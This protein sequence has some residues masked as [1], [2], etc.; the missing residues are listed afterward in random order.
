MTKKSKLVLAMASMLGITAGAAAVS[1][2]AWFTTTKTAQVNVNNI[3]VYSTSS[4]LAVSWTAGQTPVGCQQGDP[5]L[6]GL[7]V[8]GSYSGTALMQEFTTTESTTTFTLDKHPHDIVSVDIN[9]GEST[10]TV[11]SFNET[12]NVVTL[13]TA[14]ATGK[15]VKITYH[16]YEALTDLSS[17]DGQHIYKPTWTANGEGQYCTDFTA[18]SEGYVQFSMTL[19]ATGGSPLRVFLNSGASVAPVNTLNND[20]V[21][22]SHIARVAIIDNTTTRFVFQENTSY[23]SKGVSEAYTSS[24]KN[25]RL[26]AGE[27]DNDCWDLLETVTN[28]LP[29]V[30]GLLTQTAITNKAS[31]DGEWAADTD[32]QVAAESYITTVNAG[33]SKDITV[34]IWLEGTNYINEG[35]AYTNS[36]EKGAIKVNLPLIAF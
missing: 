25:H 9:N 11:D 17:V 3:G 29:T 34:T 31:H 18:A 13:T 12:T 27:G 5:S 30:T 35:G 36:P 14:V 19:T 15:K 23:G 21:Y 20:D 26:A 6:S 32:N 4:A 8:V 7:N 10:G 24:A 33:S 22:A 1:G 16:P 28:P 2:F